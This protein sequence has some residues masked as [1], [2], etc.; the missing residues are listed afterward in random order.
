[1]KSGW[2]KPLVKGYSLFNGANLTCWPNEPKWYWTLLPL[3]NGYQYHDSPS[4]DSL[5]NCSTTGKANSFG[6]IPENGNIGITSPILTWGCGGHLIGYS[7]YV[8][9]ELIPNS[10]ELE[11]ETV[12]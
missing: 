8:S 7:A 9:S 3:E 5:L 6:G 2:S 1:M 12:L 10:L 11:R 4:N